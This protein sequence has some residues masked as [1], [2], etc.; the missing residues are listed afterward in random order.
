MFAVEKV[1]S[2]SCDYS[3]LGL[4]FLLSGLGLAMLF[5]SSYY[6]GSRVF[7]DPLFFIKKQF[8]FMAAGAVC[9]FLVY[10]MNLELLRSFI[11]V[12]MMVSIF[13]M[14]LTFI[15]GIGLKI[16][17][18][19]R[20]ISVFGFSFQPSELVKLSLVLYLANIFSKKEGRLDDVVNG[21]VPPLIVSVLLCILVYLQ[22]D[23]STA[24]FIVVITLSIFFVAN[25]NFLYFIIM[26]ALVLPAG[27]LL[28]I[29]REHR[30]QRILTFLNPESDPAG[31]G[32]QVLISR[33]AVAAGDFWGA[34]PGRGTRKLGVLPEVHSDFIFASTA[35]ELGFIGAFAVIGLFA[36]FAYKGF[37]IAGR[38]EDSFKSYLAF[39]ITFTLVFQAL[40]NLAVVSGIVPATGIPLPFFSAGGSSVLI[41]L[42]MCGI[43]LKLSRE[44]KR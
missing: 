20:W 43:L 31:A 39:G 16:L 38:L 14:T 21:I 36:F 10:K 44:V 26:S 8:V 22:N 6:F 9:S 41:S 19:R 11:P 25:V 15:P 4:V 30:I 5:S 40:L 32:Y 13:L 34:G 27:A 23:F 7:D 28:L 18:A 17:G 42:I 1:K 35:E 33:Q 37:M 2:A 3:L 12:I 29:T 24:I